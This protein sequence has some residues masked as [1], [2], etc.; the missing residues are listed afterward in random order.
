MAAI[1][2]IKQQQKRQDRYS[3]YFDGK[4]VFSL[5]ESELLS[6]GLYIGKEL[7]PAEL[8][9]QQGRAQ[10]DKAYDRAIRYV[11][12]RM[13][14]EWELRQYLKRKEYDEPTIELILNKLSEKGMV[15][16][17]RFAQ[18]WVENRHLLKTIS[19]RRLQQ[20]LRQKRV[21]DDVIRTVLENDETD[22]QSELKAL[23]AKKQQITRFQDPIK[24]MQYLSRQGYSY[25]DIK[26][27]MQNDN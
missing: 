9:E 4:Y 13:R 10:L 1:T 14:S 18:A 6:S 16:D 2:D 3:I 15:D 8:A 24:L 20:E 19:K 5:G 12:L 11:A 23:I 25:D 7:T 26:S 27:A 22:E 17:Q 21:A